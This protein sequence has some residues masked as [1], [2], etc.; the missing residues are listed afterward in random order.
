M[1]LWMYIVALIAGLSLSIEGAIYGELG[2]SIGK[3]EASFYNFLVGSIILGIVLLFLG[4]GSL[5]YTF[6]APKWQLTGGLLGMT[7]LTILVI[8]VPLVGV[9]AAMISVIVGQMAM[10]MVIEHK[11]WLGSKARKVK[12]EKI[13]AVLL[14]AA[15]LILIY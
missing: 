4:K 9:G 7:Y 6:Q 13:I 12:K 14:M 15:A 2:Q 1:K 5:S 8:A 10:S 3:L 11:G